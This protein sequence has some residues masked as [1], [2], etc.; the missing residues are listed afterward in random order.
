M[1]RKELAYQAFCECCNPDL[2]VRKGKRGAS[3]F[4]N[5][6][7]QLFMYVPAFHFT[8]VPG[9]PKYRYD[10][11][12]ETGNSYSFVA[13]DCDELLT[14]IWPKLSEG[15]VKLIVTALNEDGTDYSVAGARSFFK[16]ASFP[17]K[18][19]AAKCS[20]AECAKKAYEF[21]MSQSFIK[22]WLDYGK[23]DPHYSLY[24]YPSKVISS[25]VNAMISYSKLFPEN[26]A[27]AMKVATAA[28][29]WLMAITKRGNHP[30]SDIPPTYYLDYCP[31]PKKYG[32]YTADYEN[33]VK[34]KGTVMTIYPACAGEMYLNLYKATNDK[35]YFDEATKIGMYYLNNVQKN[36]SW[37]LVVD[38]ET[39][40]PTAENYIAPIEKVCPFLMLYYECSGDERFKILCE[41]AIK[42]AEEKQYSA[43][44][45]EGQFEDTGTSSNYHNLT[46]YG[47][48][49]LAIHYA[50]Y[51]RNNK[52]KI[53]K[54]K[55]LMR[56]AEDQFVIWN[57]PPKWN[58]VAEKD[59]KW[60][61][62]CGLEQ[63][64][65]YVPIDSSA[66]HIIFGFLALY[67]AG[68]GDIYLAKAKA[69]ADQITIVQE[70]DG[71]IP[72]FWME[73]SWTKDSF[74]INCM[75]Y[76]CSALQSISKYDKIK[77][78]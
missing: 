69:L 46:Q 43:F 23:P 41:N 3:P 42:Y 36:G 30:L 72:T 58:T 18:T 26:K 71:K 37:Y 1:T 5:I 45:W 67:E 6:E 49:G 38:E 39:G 68:C 2:A 25:L 55:E 20:Y 66:S 21:A 76:S 53:E 78:E 51:Y 75:F 74:W 60:H 77:F 28:A 13:D 12:D 65:C 24:I 31:D 10:A 52:E 15:V 40:K 17:E 34:Y 56:F 73:D 61:T 19:P 11:T 33:A 7:S 44:N 50:K 70:E 47:P 8:G 9:C 14:P 29:N 27:E 54:A 59:Q 57:R 35:K 4:W 22:Y 32:I 48:V 16:L 63:Y 64:Y 62:P